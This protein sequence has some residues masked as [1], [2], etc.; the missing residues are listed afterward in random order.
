[1][2][3]SD[4]D[5]DAVVTDLATVEARLW[6]LLEAYRKELEDATIYGMPSLR[7]PGAKAHDYFASIKRGTSFV[8]LY[9]LVADTYPDALEGASPALL[10]RRTGKAA[11]TFPSLDDELAIDL[12]ALLARLYRR[13]RAD[14]A[15]T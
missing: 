9:L 4:A 14:H 8:S 12:E 3:G 5:R 2:A 11:F 7:W 6:S 15:A 10:K 13:Y 1:M